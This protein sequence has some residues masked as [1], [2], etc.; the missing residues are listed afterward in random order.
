[1]IY[2]NIW[3]M[4]I[5]AKIYSKINDSNVVRADDAKKLLIGW[6]CNKTEKLFQLKLS[7]IKHRKIFEN[8]Y[9][10]NITNEAYNKICKLIMSDKQLI[11]DYMSNKI[12]IPE[13]SDLERL[14]RLKSFW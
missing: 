10:I 14:I 7:A 4:M 9:S 5:E 3:I 12:D 8:P 13:F 2:D 11:A 6:R 1:M